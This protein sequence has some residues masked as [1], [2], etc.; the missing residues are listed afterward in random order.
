MVQ[1]ML[2]LHVVTKKHVQNEVW[3]RMHAPNIDVLELDSILY[4]LAMTFA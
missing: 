4:L 2:N 3:R 1:S